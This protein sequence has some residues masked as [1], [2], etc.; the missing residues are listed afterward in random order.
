MRLQ[1]PFSS[2][3]PTVDGS[4]LLVLAR[5]EAAFSVPEIHQLIGE[6]SEAGVRK[7]V[8]RLAGEGLLSDRRVGRTH[9]YELNRSHLAVDGVLAIARSFETLVDR[10]RARLGEFAH[11]PA[12]AALFGSAAR[13]DMRTDSDID[14][15]LVRPRGVAHEDERWS[16]D[17]ARLSADATAW[18]GN[19]VRVLAFDE[20]EIDSRTT[21]SEPVLAEIARDGVPLY[22]E[23]SYLRSRSAA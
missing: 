11:P 7:A 15:F 5:A 14:L 4:V 1:Q 13:Q 21:R 16:A 12:Y 18:T 3:T 23:T 22:G 9:V 19:D 20:E 6:Y 8:Y 17:V 10:L 2:V